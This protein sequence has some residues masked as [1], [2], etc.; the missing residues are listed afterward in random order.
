[1]QHVNLGN[2]S[3][4]LKPIVWGVSQRSVLDSLLFLICIIDLT[5]CCASSKAVLFADDTAVIQNSKKKDFSA[6]YLEVVNKSL[7]QSLTLNQDNI[8]LIMLATFQQKTL[9]LE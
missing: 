3:S 4:N 5:Q 8:M 2:F 9:I 1:M 7:N 6:Q